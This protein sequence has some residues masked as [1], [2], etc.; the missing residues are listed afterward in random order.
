MKPCKRRFINPKFSDLLEIL[1]KNKSIAIAAFIVGLGYCLIEAQ[2][3]GDLLIFL[4]AAGDL[5]AHRDID[6]VKYFDRYQYYYSVLF[7]IL[8]QP[9]WHLSFDWEKFGWLLLNLALFVHLFYLFA[10]FLSKRFDLRQARLVLIFTFAFSLRFLHK[11]LHASQITILIFWCCVTGLLQIFK[12]RELSGALL[13]A[14]GINIK[15]LPVVFIPYLLYRGFFK[16]TGY[17][18][19]FYMVFLILPVFIIGYDYNGQ[20]LASWFSRINPLNTQHIMDTDE[21][22]FHSLTTLITTLLVAHPPDPLAM[23]L[24]RNI[25]DVSLPVL[26]AVILAVRIVLMMFTLYF[27]K[28]RSIFRRGHYNVVEISYL[29][30]LIPLI[31]PHQQHYAFLFAVPAF[32][33]V[34]SKLVVDHQSMSRWAVRVVSGI[35]LLIFLCGNLKILLGEFNRYY[36]HYKILTYGALLLIPLLAWVRAYP[37]KAFDKGNVAGA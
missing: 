25:A 6:A 28:A 32:A 10:Q 8:L 30:L 33:L 9:M 13:L 26:S 2:G 3:P 14:I 36:E 27:L 15:L 20:L 23:Q 12:G 31:F 21:R 22:S 37:L 5:A 29:L 16:S 24:R 11:N 18:L 17:I 19:L 7:A 4:S 35:L 1:F 34:V